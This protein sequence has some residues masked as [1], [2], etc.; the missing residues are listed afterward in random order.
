LHGIASCIGPTFAS[1]GGHHNPLG[2]SHGLDGAPGAHAGDLPNLEV[3]VAGRGRL[4]GTTERATL[5]AGPTSLFDG[6][7][8]AVVIHAAEDDQVTDPTGNSGARVACGVI[9]VDR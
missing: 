9:E 1:A 2:A 5:S 3:N 7:G 4:Q 6:D 8:A